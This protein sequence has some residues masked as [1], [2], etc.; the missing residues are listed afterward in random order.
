MSKKLYVGNLDYGTTDESLQEFVQSCG[1]VVSVKVVKDNFSGRSKGFAF[2]EF[3]SDEAAQEC[4]NSLNG[5]ELNG[6]P[7]K[8]S[9][10]RERERSDSRGGNRGGGGGGGRGGFG[11]GYSGG[12]GFGGG[13]G[14]GGRG[15]NDRQRRDRW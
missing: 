7:L 11:G 3:A 13:G 4:V 6:R 14:G 8:I 12:G 1:E 5:A 10:A 2:V 15:G 9:E